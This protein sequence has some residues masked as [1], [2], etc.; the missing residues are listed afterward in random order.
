MSTTVLDRPR[1]LGG[2][3][4]GGAPARRA[5]VRWAWRLFRREW[6]Q[7]L[8]VLA[9]ISVAV[10]ATILGGAV[11]TNTPPPA[12]TGF[13]TANH[14][15]TLPGT[16]SHLAGDIAAIEQGFGTADVI[17]NQDIATG[18]VQGAHLRAQ[19][20]NGAY[21][22]PMLDLLSGRHPS[23]AGEVAVTKRL[24]STF[25]LHL[26]DVW[27][28]PGRALGVVGLVENPQNLLDNFALLA[29]G[30]LNSPS[31]VTVL[32]NATASKAA[33]FTFP[34]GRAR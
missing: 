22:R 11:A 18:F 19:D 17:E 31:Q 27:H 8:L 16:D 29:P 25:N 2:G 34:R 7:Q 23:G 33:V 26:G 14:L 10:A 1:E 24:A 6:R 3:G 9:L 28:E 12:N 21:G 15:H 5:V 30:Q 4:N 32:F 20:P 13:G